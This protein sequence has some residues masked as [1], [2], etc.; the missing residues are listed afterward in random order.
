MRT[1]RIHD[2]VRKRALV[3]RE[4][5]R[6]IAEAL[7]Q[8][9]G[10]DNEDVT[11]DFAGVDAVTPS[12]VDEVLAVFETTLRRTS[13]SSFR[14]LVVNSPTRLSAKFSAVAR[15]RGLEIAESSSGAWTIS[16]PVQSSSGG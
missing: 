6:P 7:S 16:R 15:A 11:L 14:L 13:R 9:N 10:T 5:A 4:S 3:T 8:A 12:F 1:L 2:L